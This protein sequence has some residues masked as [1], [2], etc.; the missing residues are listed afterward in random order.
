MKNEKAQF[1]QK[2]EEMLQHTSDL[3]S[4]VD[5]QTAELKFRDAEIERLQ[6]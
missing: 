3:I 6:S 1:A 2:E 5:D 4:I